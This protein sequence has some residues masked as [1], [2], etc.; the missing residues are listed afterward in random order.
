MSTRASP[1]RESRTRSR[2]EKLWSLKS[3]KEIAG[4]I[5]SLARR[6]IVEPV[7]E[8]ITRAVK[9][10]SCVAGEGRA[11]RKVRLRKAAK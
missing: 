10:P 8:A 7:D 2:P 5:A 11:A 6:G 4:E 1:P 3:K 9:S